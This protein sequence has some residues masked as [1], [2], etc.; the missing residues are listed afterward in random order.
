MERGV[1]VHWLRHHFIPEDTDKLILKQ[2]GIIYCLAQK[3][4]KTVAVWIQISK[5]LRAYDW[6]IIE[7][8]NMFQLATIILTLSFNPQ[9]VVSHLLSEWS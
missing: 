2:C 4:K 8:I 6:I 1:F 7:V 5:Y 3:K 9:C